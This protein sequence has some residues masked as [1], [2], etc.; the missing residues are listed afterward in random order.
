MYRPDK[1]MKA[2]GGLA[3]SADCNAN[4][5]PTTNRAFVLE[6]SQPNPTWTEIDTLNYAR[7]HHVLVTLANGEVMALGGSA[8]T[9]ATLGCY[10]AALSPEIINPDETTPTWRVMASA[11]STWPE[12]LPVEE[13]GVRY[14]HSVGL[15]LPD[16]RVLSAGGENHDEDDF[17]PYRNAQI[18]SPPYLFDSYGE[19]ADRPTIV[20]VTGMGADKMLY[21]EVASVETPSAAEAS[22]IVK[23]SLLRLGAMTHSFDH[24]AR[25]MWLNFSVDPQNTDT[26]LVTAPATGNHA[27]PGYYMMFI[28][29]EEGVPSVAKIVQIGADCNDNDVFDFDDLMAGT[30][31]D[32]NCNRL[33]DQ[34]EAG[35]T[36]AAKKNRHLSFST[37]VSCDSEI[38]LGAIEIRLS[39]M[40]RCSGDDSLSCT[41]NSDC[42][43]E[44]IC[45]EH[46]DVG[47]TRWVGEPFDIT[48][49]S[50]DHLPLPGFPDC[51]RVFYAR[52][53]SSPV[54]R[55]WNEE[56]VHITDCEIVP[57]ATYQLRGTFNG[58]DFTAPLTIST[59]DK[60]TNK[61]YGDVVGGLTAGGWT[62]PQGVVNVTDIQAVLLAQQGAVTAP[63]TTWA[64]LFGPVQGAAPDGLITAD[65]IQRAIFA[66]EGDA[67]TSAPEQ[68]NPSL[69]S[70][71]S[72]AD[73]AAGQ[74]HR[75]DACG[76][77][78]LPRSAGVAL[79]RCLHRCG[80]R[81]GCL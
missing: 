64:D 50:E 1:I 31:T 54:Y 34:C 42:P 10:G 59:I 43:T 11:D 67:Y 17:I 76:Q 48:C 25:F 27:P 26:V 28:I 66:F 12:Y 22:N 24:D 3:G 14:Y 52:V 56:V 8:V 4:D 19:L 81:L 45:G 6:A 78:R 61:H 23:V 68:V 30:L 51:D 55:P 44:Q 46:V 29:N 57:V 40:R 7:V 41:F 58:T 77:R 2:G 35:T 49:E 9:S 5:D 32:V 38:F 47:L 79:R 63:H 13:Q 69:M 15:L 62:F 20:S 71:H 74:S 16:G 37:R 73:Y 39:S 53:V 80:R 18:F 36:H 75:A 65:D 21:G 72:D 70:G 33:P 60:P